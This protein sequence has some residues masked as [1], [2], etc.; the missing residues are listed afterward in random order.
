[1]MFFDAS[2][3]VRELHLPQ[4]PVEEALREAVEWFWAHGYAPR[5]GGV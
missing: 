4:T 1:I 3:A 2:K 5:K